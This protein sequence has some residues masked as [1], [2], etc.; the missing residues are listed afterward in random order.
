MPRYAAFQELML[1]LDNSHIHLRKIAGQDRVQLKCLIQAENA[2]DLEDKQRSLNDKT[3]HTP[4][5]TYVDRIHRNNRYCMYDVH[6]RDLA[7]ITAE[8][9]KKSTTFIHNF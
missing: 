7:R 8:C 2:V 6:V 5:Y 9:N 4:T 1:S 3:S